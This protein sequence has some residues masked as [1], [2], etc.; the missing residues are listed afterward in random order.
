MLKPPS[1]KTEKFSQSGAWLFVRER[2]IAHYGDIADFVDNV[3]NRQMMA[4]AQRL[5]RRMIEEAQRRLPP[6]TTN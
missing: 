1:F 5:E 6:P 2:W 4:E 3:I